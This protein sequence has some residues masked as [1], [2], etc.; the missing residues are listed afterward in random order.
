MEHHQLLSGQPDLGR[1][2]DG[3]LQLYPLLYIHERQVGGRL[4]VFTPEVLN[5]NS[6]SNQETVDDVSRIISSADIGY[7]DLFT[8][9]STTSSPT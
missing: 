5:Y 6:G 9:R 7:S 2:H 1:P 8:V 3:H 4:V